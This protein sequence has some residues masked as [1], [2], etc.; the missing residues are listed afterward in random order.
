MN[1]LSNV[2]ALFSVDSPNRCPKR[3]HQQ[4]LWITRRTPDETTPVVARVAS[5]V[6]SQVTLL[7]TLLITQVTA[8]SLCELHCSQ[9]DMRGRGSHLGCGLNDVHAAPQRFKELSA[10]DLKSA[11]ISAV[12]TSE[13]LRGREVA[14]IKAPFLAPQ[15]VPQGASYSAQM[16][17]EV[18]GGRAP[19]EIRVTMGGRVLRTM[20]VFVRVDFFAEGWAL[21]AD[22]SAGETISEGDLVAVRLPS[23]RFSR[24]AVRSAELAVGAKLRR[25][26]NA[27]T[28][29][30]EAW[31]SIPPLVR[32]GATVE[33]VFNRGGISLTAQGEALTD[34]R[35]GAMIRVRNLKSKKIV[36]GRVIG[37]NRV[38]VGR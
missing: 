33:L 18:R 31:L 8:L 5:R 11:V 16:S 35:R 24:D 34:G 32:R 13:H 12:R 19:V 23:S 17:G 21:N 15:R 9:L 37:I 20:R 26:V 6:I 10:A 3:A 22:R 2:S 29:L 1:L 27:Q 30:R 25:N 7:I 28:P 36:T 38:E 4:G 14:E